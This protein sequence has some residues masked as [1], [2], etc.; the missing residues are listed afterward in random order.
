M[1]TILKKQ[2]VF[3]SGKKGREEIRR[4]EAEQENTLKIE[5]VQARGKAP[6]E[7]LDGA[8]RRGEIAPEKSA[9]GEVFSEDEDLLFLG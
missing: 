1:H 4:Q 8:R 6:Q 2:S 5:T 7:D 3:F 9:T